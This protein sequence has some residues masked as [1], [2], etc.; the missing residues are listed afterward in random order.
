MSKP[1]MPQEVQAKVSQWFLGALIV[2]LATAG[3]AAVA[4]SAFRPPPGFAGDFIQ[5][6]LSARDALDGRPVYSNLPDALRRHLGEPVNNPLP[7]NAHP[8]GSILLALPLARLDH[9]DAFFAWNLIT[10]PL[11]VIAVWI[12]VAELGP[13]TGWRAAGV[14]GLVSVLGV[15]SF[16]LYQQVILGQF[17]ALLA[18]L[19]A[20]AWVADRRGWQT[21]TGLSV[22]LAVA[23]K[24]FPAF[25]F[26]Y[27]F[28][29]RR[30]R[31]AGVAALTALAINALAIALFGVDA[32]RTYVRDVVPAVSAKYATYWNN[33]SVSAFWLRLFDPT[34][35]S[36]VVAMSVA[37]LTGKLLAAASRFVVVVVVGLAAWRARTIEARDRALALATIGMV[38]A[39]PI[40]WPH[41]LVLLVVPVGVLIAATVRTPWRWP[42]LVCLL[43]MWLPDTFVPALVL[44]REQAEAMSVHRHRPLTAAEN[45]LVAS[46]P[47]Y[48]LVGLFL[49]VFRLPTAQRDTNTAG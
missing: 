36:G 18:F 7:W 40:A 17:N 28:A 24:L 41:Y 44:G 35:E 10:F 46:V 45:L 9:A 47:H 49:L 12:V 29:A 30:W 3:F 39:S 15:T 14:A 37:P 6:W 1:E 2:A 31:A 22:G 19:L 23:V 43:I 34:T 38:L 33:L 42:L 16:P 8:P 48:A 5:D 4:G 25:L 21:L 32:Y 26:L 13:W 20:V 11:L 27:L